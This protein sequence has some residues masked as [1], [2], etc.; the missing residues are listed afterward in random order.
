M[1][2]L[3]NIP[4]SELAQR[5]RE[6]CQFKHKVFPGRRV[7]RLEKEVHKIKGELQKRKDRKTYGIF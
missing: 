4:T 5:L 1:E 2:K 6:L 3:S 7:G